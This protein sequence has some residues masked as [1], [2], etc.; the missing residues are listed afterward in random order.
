MKIADFSSAL[1]RSALAGLTVA[2]SATAVAQVSINEIDYDQPGS[3][4][5]EFIELYNAGAG[6]VNLSNYTI[7]LVNGNNDTPYNTI[8]LGNV[9]IAAGDF[10]VICADAANV[11]NCDLEGFSSVQNGA[12]DAVALFDNG[13]IIDAVSYEGDVAAPYTEGSGVG[14]EDASGGGAGGP[15]DFKSIA[16]FPDGND[17]DVN[18]VDLAHVCMSPGEANLNTTSGCL[19]PAVEAV[20]INEIDYQETGITDNEFVEIYNSGNTDIDLSTYSVQLVDGFTMNPYQT[21]ALGSVVLG[22]GE[23]YVV[24]GSTGVAN[25]DLNTGLGND[26]IENGSPD[27]VGLLDG[28]T[29]VDTVSY[30]GSVFGFTEGSGSGL[31][32]DASLEIAGISRFP[33]GSDI[34]NN[35]VDFDVRCATP[36]APNT[37]VAA[38]CNGGANTPIHTIQGNGLSSPL[39]GQIVTTNDNIVTGVGPEGFF[40]Q[41]P[42]ANADADSDTSE[43]IYVF[44]A[45]PPAVQVG[46]Q[47]DVTGLVEEFFNFTEITSSPLVSIDS[48]G[49]ALPSSI[50]LSSVLP[51]PLQPQSP[52]E[53]ER[54]EGMIATVVGLTTG[55]TDRFGD[56]P[57][58]A[59]TERAFREP[60]IEFPGLPNLPVWDGNPELIEIDADALGL[61]DELLFGGQ[62]ITAIGPVAFAF[63]DYQIW[64]TAL[65]AGIPPIQPRAV[66]AAQNGEFT[67]ATQNFERFFDNIDDPGVD[68]TV[69]PLAEYEARLEKVSYQIRLN[70][71]SPDIVALQEIES[72]VVM[73]DIADRITLDDPS[74]VYNVH[75]IEGNDVGGIDVGFLTNDDTITVSATTQI[76]PNAILTFDGSLLNDRPPLQIDAQYTGGAEPF[77][78]TVINVHQR[79]LG[80]IDGSSAER[81]KTKRFEQSETLALYIQ[82]LQVNNPDIHLVVTGD[83]NAY[84]F[85]DG[86]VDVVG[87]ISGNPDPLGAEFTATDVVNPDLTNQVLSLPP[88]ERYSFIFSGSAQVLDHTLTSSELNQFVTGF[89]F[90]RGNTDV[91]ESV[92]LLVGPGVPPIADFTAVRSTDHDGAALYITPVAAVDTDGDGVVD[93]AD[94]CTL[95]ANPT[96][97]DSNGDGFGNICDPDLDNNGI[98]NFFD[99]V[100]IQM[101]FFA[102]PVS[103]NWNPDADFDNNGAINFLDFVILTN[104]FLSPPGP[105]GIAP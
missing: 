13:T 41:T 44:T 40:I 74:L 9:D 58:T 35:S 21:I 80:G 45:T 31:I 22:P 87:Q 1:V 92:Q 23:F 62:E 79:S 47:V 24:C 104:L 32:D 89:E 2:L 83:F 57:I 29:L 60:G 18:N 15:N 14:L 28:S 4:T 39:A 53:L 26:F 72:A 36:G 10:F 64:P 96:Q 25:C 27:A 99:L 11:A 103:P 20:V 61:P 37:S 75:L 34:G 101:A 7:E 94:N 95:V 105:S 66:R 52:I 50:L 51:S 76:N 48:S 46:D 68:D 55:G 91:P 38:A 59:Q 69:V 49:N 81:V 102:T 70:L 5:A 84:E 54:Y 77:D 43:G 67:I 82:D 65:S 12:P 78:I 85:T 33:D 100:Q 19:P 42:D 63:G 93:S 71:G 30:D 73:Q 86:F 6:V 98:V 16:R 17:T 97:F 3:D 88:E 8:S 90:A 56:T